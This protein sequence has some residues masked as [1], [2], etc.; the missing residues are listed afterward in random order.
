MVLG[1]NILIVLIPGKVDRAAGRLY[2]S[3]AGLIVLRALCTSKKQ[4]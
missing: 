1:T 3:E 2:V 4:A